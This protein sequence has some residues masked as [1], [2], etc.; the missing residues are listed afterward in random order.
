MEELKLDIDVKEFNFVE[1]AEHLNFVLGVMGLQATDIEVCGTKKGY[2]IRIILD[3]ELEEAKDII[4][5]Q[6]ILG[7]D[8]N[9]ELFGYRRVLN[10]VINWNVLFNKKTTKQ[11]KILSREKSNKSA[12][13]LL[14]DYVCVKQDKSC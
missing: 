11:G 14:G 13:K 4:I 8:R 1:F 2:H 10:N 7:S 9:R 3:R 6:L 12:T 5:L